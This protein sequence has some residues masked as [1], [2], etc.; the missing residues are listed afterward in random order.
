MDCRRL[1]GS[2]DVDAQ[3]TRVPEDRDRQ[4]DRT[5]RHISN[6][7]E[8][9]V[10]HLLPAARLVEFHHLH[11]FGVIEIGNRRIVERNMPILPHSHARG[12]A[13]GPARSKSA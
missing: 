9:A 7:R 10:M 4:G 12:G 5:P 8:T 2:M 6:L 1:A 13:I 3:A 11:K